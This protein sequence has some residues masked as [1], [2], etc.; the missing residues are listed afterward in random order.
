MKNHSPGTG[1]AEKPAVNALINKHCPPKRIVVALDPSRASEIAWE[2]AEILSKI[3]RSK[4]EGVYVQPWLWAG[5]SEFGYADPQLTAK[6][7]EETVERLWR[8]VK[9]EDIFIHDYGTVAEAKAGL[10][11]FF[12]FYN[13]ER[14]HQSLDYQTPAC[15]YWQGRRS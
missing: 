11:K 12:P 14:L 2:E 6:T 15:V 10:R 1:V 5:N 7:S 3:W 9:Y 8:T 4:V 13:N